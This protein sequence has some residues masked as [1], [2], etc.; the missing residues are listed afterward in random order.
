MVPTLEDLSLLRVTRVVLAAAHR[1]YDTAN[2]TSG[3]LVAFCQRCHMNHDRPEHRWR[4]WRTLFRR[5]ALGDLFTG[6]YK[7]R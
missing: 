3:N 4:R 7:T 5:R 1:D 6:P 2:Y